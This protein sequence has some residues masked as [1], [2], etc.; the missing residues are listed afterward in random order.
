MKAFGR[1][2]SWPSEGAEHDKAAALGHARTQIVR[3][4]TEVLPIVTAMRALA[5][6]TMKKDDILF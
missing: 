1:L 5:I 4:V 2:H 3:G 6:Q